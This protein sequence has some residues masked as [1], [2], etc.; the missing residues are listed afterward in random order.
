MGIRAE[1]RQGEASEE[2]EEDMTNDDGP[3][4]AFLVFWDS[5]ASACIEKGHDRTGHFASENEVKN[6]GQSVRCGVIR[7]EPG[8]EGFVSGS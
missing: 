2:A 7:E 6:S 3:E 1:G 4:V 8:S 5:N